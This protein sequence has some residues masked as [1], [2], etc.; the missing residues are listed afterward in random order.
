MKSIVQLVTELKTYFLGKDTAAKQAVEASIAP[1]ETD[2][3]SSSRNYTQGKQLILGDVL[4]DVTAAIS[5]GDALTV[6]TNIS[7][8]NS[9]TDQI[10]AIPRALAGLSDVDLTSPA[11]G[12][13]LRYNGTSHKWENVIDKTLTDTLAAGSTSV[14]FVDAAITATAKCSVWTSPV[15]NYTAIDDST[16]NTVVI[17]FPAQ[18][19]PVTV[20][21]EIRG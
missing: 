14:T 1:V 4:Y 17:T 6:G 21:L 2:A 15:V 20:G 19:S 12:D 11:D 3:T 13:L 10:G 8:A 9:I 7:A 18:A 16:A 5:V